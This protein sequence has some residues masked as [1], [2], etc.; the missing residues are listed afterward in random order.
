MN[1]PTTLSCWGLR[2]SISCT[3]EELAS[4]PPSAKTT[5]KSASLSNVVKL[6][7]TK[8]ERERREKYIESNNTELIL[9]AKTNDPMC[10]QLELRLSFVISLGLFSLLV[11]RWHRC[12]MGFRKLTLSNLVTLSLDH[13]SVANPET[14]ERECWE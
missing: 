12:K 9:T 11:K 4:T 8:K 2:D 10:F 5:S 1:R 7:K 6:I 13:F 3:A 14:G